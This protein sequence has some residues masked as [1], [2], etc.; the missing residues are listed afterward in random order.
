MDTLYSASMQAY[1]A[2][3][4]A[5]LPTCLPE[6]DDL[7]NI[8]IEAMMYACSAGGKRIRPVLTLE[9][10]RLCGG[11]TDSALPFAAAVEMIH[12]YS[13][14]H[15]DLP[16]MDN[17]P[18]RRGKPSVHVAFGENMALLAGDA[19]LNRAFE[20]MLRSEAEPAL[21]VAAAKTLADQAGIAGMVG[22]QVIDLQSE[23]K[24]IPLDVLEQLQEGK[25]AA[26]M[27]AACKMGAIIGKGTAVQIDAAAQFGREIGLGFQIVDDILDA[28]VSVEELGKPVGNDAAHEKSTYVTLLGLD[29]ARTLAQERTQAAID[30][31]SVFGVEADSLRQL[32]Q[33]L[34]IR[35]H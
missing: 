15:D 3:I 18:L 20:V 4:E 34:L 2:Q 30:A 14:I 11:D 7:R 10:C 31:L 23:G 17:S 21:I 27:I 29:K 35:T 1:L 26:L 24:R 12:S 5:Y 33:A 22:G 9:C 32:A 16:C 28:T 19:L 25:T 8:V 13:L 6:K